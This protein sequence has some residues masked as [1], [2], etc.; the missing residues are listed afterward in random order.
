MIIYYSRH[1]DF[2][3][4]QVRHKEA[5]AIY[6][7]SIFVFILDLIFFITCKLSQL[8]TENYKIWDKTSSKTSTTTHGLLKNVVN[9][10]LPIPTIKKV[11]R[12]IKCSVSF[13]CSVQYKVLIVTFLE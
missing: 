12:V 8:Y 13:M 2:H 1:Q 4:T 6:R 7:R 5:P 3:L 10:L 11:L 9:A